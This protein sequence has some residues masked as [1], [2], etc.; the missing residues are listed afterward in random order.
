MSNQKERVY[1]AAVIV[2]GNEVLSGRIQDKNLNFLAKE[3][4]ELGIRLR[5]GRVI[6]DVEDVIVATVNELRA[7]HDYVFTTGGIGPTH[8][9]ITAQTVADAFG[10][11][12]ERNAQATA[13]LEEYYGDAV[14]E[15]RMRMANIPQGGIL[16]DNPV[17]KA[18]G[19]Q[20]GNVYVLPGVPRIMQ[21]IF[22]G[23]K[24]RLAGGRPMLSRTVTAFLM[25]SVAA[26]G[27]SDI[28]TQFANTE[29]GSYPFVRNQRFG[30][31]LVVRSVDGDELGAATDAVVTLV[32]S[33]GAEPDVVEGEDKASVD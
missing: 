6:P 20:L 25:E 7:R 19:F 3:L 22:D 29:I 15:S 26:P 23:F 5:E 27:L 28:Q 33:L 9:D 14:N 4:K 2:I 11:P 24:H 17:S 13:I 31:A 8:D 32:R 21:A 18:P 1:T 30:T 10:V 12:L 16:L